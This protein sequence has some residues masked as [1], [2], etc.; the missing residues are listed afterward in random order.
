MP[1]YVTD[2]DAPY[3]PELLLWLNADGLVVGTTL[4]K[5]GELLARAS[6]HLRATI[7]KPMIGPPR[8]PGRLRVASDV[9]AASLR[10]DH[11]SIEI[12]VGPT[13]EIDQVIEDMSEHMQSAPEIPQSMLGG[14]VAPEAMASFFRAAAALFRAKPWKLVPADA[15]LS[16]TAE[17]RGLREGAL[18]VIG[19]MG[20]SFG[21]LLFPS[22]DDFNAYLDAAESIERGESPPTPEY[23]VLNFERGAEL[24]P[25]VRKEISSHKW[26]VAG[27][28]A[29]PW[30]AC[31]DQTMVSRPPTAKELALLEAVALAVAAL[32]SEKQAVLAAF[33]GGEP[34]DR[35]YSVPT[36]E[37]NIVVN[38]R[39]PHPR[40]PAEL[41]E[42]DDVLSALAQLEEDGAID[43]VDRR[44]PLED[45]LVA[46]FRA[47]PEGSAV[48]AMEGHRMVMQF[49][50]DFLGASIA[51]L[52]P[53][54]LREV[55][56]EIIPR[57]VSVDP[58]SAG[59]II[60]DCR[61][62]YRFLKHAF[63]LALAEDCLRVLGPSTAKKLEQGLS[64]PANFGMAKSIL[65]AGKEAGF[66]IH[67]KEGI[68][69]WLREV[70][71]KPL[72][73]SV[74][75]PFERMEPQTASG[76]DRK[77]KD[78]RKAARKARKKNR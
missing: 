11:P 21:F 54:E 31:V 1:A 71:G 12:R 18:S 39:A 13:P 6:G 64:D 73:A 65:M 44:Q 32:A 40:Q 62:F 67:S 59:A 20:Q 17:A 45:E 69:A 9:L 77:K 46:A 74:R 5:P 7:A 49:A 43:D 41:S 15:L 36:P 48:S 55:L 72:P 10:A 19:Q 52:E 22:V 16:V 23:L 50:G 78:R 2:S 35:V 30:V 51:T 57:K 56:L 33:G 26:E 27:P 63:G 24:D 68:E 4:G 14:G 3:R 37:G 34:F 8:S 61:A 28:R 75:L 38:V 70:Q 53:A 47:S 42:P 29:Y 66:D 58:A 25:A 76:L 60:A